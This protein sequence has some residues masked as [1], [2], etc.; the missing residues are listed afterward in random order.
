MESVIRTLDELVERKI[1]EEYVIGGA[2]ALIYFS[3]PT[4]TE[5]IDVFVYMKEQRS[6]VDLSRIYEFLVEHK[7]ATVEKEYVFIDRF[8]LQFLVPYDG[9]S[10]EAFKQAVLVEYGGLPVKIFSLE[11]LMA[12]MIQLNKAKYRERLRLLI[13]TQIFDNIRLS[14]ILKRHGLMARWEILSRELTTP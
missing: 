13:E 1:I 10:D 5:D 3:T 11:Y 8:P 4:L 12:I 9:L 6:L 14:A 7:G 2:T